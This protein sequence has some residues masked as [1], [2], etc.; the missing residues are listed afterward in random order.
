MV[1]IWKADISQTT[2]LALWIDKKVS[3]SVQEPIPLKVWWYRVGIAKHIAVHYLG[4]GSLTTNELV[5]G[6]HSRLD[7]FDDVCFERC[8]LVLNGDGILSRACQ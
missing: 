2:R 7:D 8:K 4:V 6:R 1:L 5:E 3:V